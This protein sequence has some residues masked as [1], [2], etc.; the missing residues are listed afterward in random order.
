MSDGTMR[1]SQPPN[2]A[3]NDVP[4]VVPAGPW[5]P[6]RMHADVG[7]GY[8]PPKPP[9]PTLPRER[10]SL[11]KVPMTVKIA[12]ALWLL[13]GIVAVISPIATWVTA[14]QQQVAYGQYMNRMNPAAGAVTQALQGASNNVTTPIFIALIVGA[15]VGLA[16]YVV[17]AYFVLRGSRPARIIATVLTGLSL[18]GIFGVSFFG[19]LLFV[20]ILLNVAGTVLV[21]LP[22]SKVLFAIRTDA[23]ARPVGYVSPPSTQGHWTRG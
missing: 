4:R 18:I 16:G 5:T 15:I 13:A 19:G 10:L 14:A 22:A 23:Q 21:W 3:S 2:G 11:S 12:V 7:F 1:P 6:Q 17:V 20:Q 8:V 9:L